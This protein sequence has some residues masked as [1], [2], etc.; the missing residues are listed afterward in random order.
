MVCQQKCY[1]FPSFSK[2]GVGVVCKNYVPTLFLM[3]ISAKSNPK[4]QKDFR[5]SLRNNLTPSEAIL[6]QYLKKGQVGG[7]KFRRQHGLGSYVMDFYC[8]A[9]KLCIELDGEVHDSEQAFDHDEARTDFLKENG[10]SVLRFE[11]YIVHTDPQAIINAIL[12]FAEERK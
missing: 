1:L 6:W 12:L 10:I 4:S 2:G 11:N 9:L 8:P 7:H 5:K 3:Y